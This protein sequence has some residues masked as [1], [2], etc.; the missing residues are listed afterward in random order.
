[1]KFGTC[2]QLLG[3]ALTISALLSLP[4]QA[5]TNGQQLIIRSHSATQVRVTGR[6]Q[7]GQT[8]TWTA[9]ADGAAVNRTFSTP[10]WWWKG[11]VTV[12]VTYKNR[13]SQTCSANVPTRQ[14]THWFNVNCGGR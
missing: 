1:M 11:N 5:G 13:T 4:A 14:L 12:V 7:S 3:S 6:N 9:S 10:N 2:F 8:V